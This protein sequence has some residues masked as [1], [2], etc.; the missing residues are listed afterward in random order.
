MAEEKEYVGEVAESEETEATPKKKQATPRM[1]LVDPDKKTQENIP[2]VAS[3]V[4]V[5]VELASTNEE[6]LELMQSKGPFSIVMAEVKADGVRGAEVLQ[7][8][9]KQSPS[10]VRIL[11]AVHLDTKVLED[12]V[13]AGEPYRFLKK[14]VDNK[15]LVKSLQESLRQYK[16]N[17]TTAGQ[18]QLLEKLSAEFKTLK[19]KYAELKEQAAK[20]KSNLRSVFTVIGVVIVLA[21]GV[22]GFNVYQEGKEIEDASVRYGAWVLFPNRTAKDSDTG[23]TWMSVDFRIIEKRAPKNWE[24]ANEWVAKMNE[25]EFGGFSDWRLPTL[26]EYKTT[27]DPNHSKKAFD[28]REDY[29]VGYPLAFEDGGGYGYWASDSTSDTNAA[30]FFFIGGY[31]KVVARDYFSPAMSVRLVRG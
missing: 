29:K 24:E 28:N 3:T 16:Q 20:L 30:Y 15:L 31:D 9:R 13:N 5:V 17:Q 19:T 18:G 21:G 1:L 14:P 23:K 11:A 4:G 8:I 26:E 2:K 12:A 6:A 22:Y 7:K 10:T 27:Y 25:K